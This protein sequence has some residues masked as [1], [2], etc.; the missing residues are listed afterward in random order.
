MLNRK[1]MRSES[2]DEM[3]TASSSD[4][5]TSKETLSEKRMRNE[6]DDETSTAS[7]EDIFSSSGEDDSES[8]EEGAESSEEMNDSDESEE[9]DPWGVLIHEAA[10]EL[11]TKHN[12]IVQ[13]LQNGGFSEID[14]KKQAFSEILPDLRKKLGNIYFDRLKWMTQMKRV[15]CIG[16]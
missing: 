15:Q 2:D 14:A 10:M 1:R 12:E 13:S 3:S 9:E 5:R 11:R 16:K 7:D 6:Y 4:E 8:F